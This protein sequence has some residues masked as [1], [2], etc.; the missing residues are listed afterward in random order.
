M[1]ST[2]A[3]TVRS[4]IPKYLRL[5]VYLFAALFEKYGS[6]GSS[7][8]GTVHD[9]GCEL[10]RSMN[11]T[12]HVIVYNDPRENYVGVDVFTNFEAGA[13]LLGWRISACNGYGG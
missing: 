12:A 9:V 5:Y 6:T 7:L 8:R 13:R 11:A 4:G 10:L 1:S 2:G 3:T